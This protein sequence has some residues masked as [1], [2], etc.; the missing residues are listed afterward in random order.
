[1]LRI[2]RDDS[3]VVIIYPTQSALQASVAGDKRSFQNI[4]ASDGRLIKRE[5]WLW[6][7]EVPAGR[8]AASGNVFLSVSNTRAVFEL[9]ACAH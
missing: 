1:M 7:N 8:V 6:L 2:R 3:I 4:F 9:H 5:S